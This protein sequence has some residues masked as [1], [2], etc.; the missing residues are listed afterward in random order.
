MINFLHLLAITLTFSSAFITLSAQAATI[1][2]KAELSSPLVSHH[3]DTK[4]YLKISLAGVDLSPSSEMIP[5]NVAIVL[6]QS[7]S[8]RG[9]KIRQAKLAAMQAVEQLSSNDIVSIIASD[10]GRS[11]GS[12]G[13]TVT[14]IG[15]G[16]GYNEDLMV[17][18]C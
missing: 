6:D 16:D 13:I 15:L 17:I 7:G 11:L 10:L 1:E 14:T 9:H 5:V 3:S 12:E 4:V 2:L 8:M 18:S